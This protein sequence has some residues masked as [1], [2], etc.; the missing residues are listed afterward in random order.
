MYKGQ[1]DNRETLLK[2]WLR[3]SRIRV[4]IRIRVTVT[5]TVTFKS[6]FLTLNAKPKSIL[7][8][9][10]FLTPILILTLSLTLNLLF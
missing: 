4:R 6:F 10:P 9:T 7:T 3:V 8:V 1:W 5:V 2:V